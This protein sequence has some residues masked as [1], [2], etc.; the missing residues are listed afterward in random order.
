[1]HHAVL[2]RVVANNHTGGLVHVVNHCPFRTL[3]HIRCVNADG[4]VAVEHVRGRKGTI[5]KV[6]GIERLPHNVS[7]GDGIAVFLTQ[8]IN[9]LETS[10]C[11]ECIDSVVSWS[12]HR[13]S[14]VGGEQVE[15]L[16]L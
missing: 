11:K 5:R 12:E 9:R 6:G 14:A 15:H 2:H 3:R 8:F 16:R 7:I 10:A 4:Q 13:V 1:M